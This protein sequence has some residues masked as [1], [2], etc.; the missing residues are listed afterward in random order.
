MSFSYA[1]RSS[2]RRRGPTG[3][4]AVM[5]PRRHRPAEDAGPGLPGPARAATPARGE[6][7]YDAVAEQERARRARAE[8]DRALSSSERL[9]RLH[10]LC[11]QL[12][13]ITPARPPDGP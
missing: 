9:E 8:R 12:A 6:V 11:A 4:R 1:R 10:R 5:A 13:T 3:Y 2:T 7:G